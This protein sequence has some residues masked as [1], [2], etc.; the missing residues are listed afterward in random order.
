MLKT[1]KY[2]LNNTKVGKL[3]RKPKRT[4]PNKSS[5]QSKNKAAQTEAQ[6]HDEKTRRKKR[7]GS[8]V[9]AQLMNPGFHGFDP[10]AGA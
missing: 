8:F 6:V 2:S 4:K 1:A 7:R 5:T 3:K 10:Y 9:S